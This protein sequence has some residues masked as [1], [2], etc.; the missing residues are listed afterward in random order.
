VPLPGDLTPEDYV[1]DI[2]RRLGELGVTIT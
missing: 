2:T 1:D